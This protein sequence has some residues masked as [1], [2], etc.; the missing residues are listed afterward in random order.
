MI[1]IK[2]LHAYYGPVEVLKGIDV[3][4][5]DGE[6]TCLIGN[7]GAGKST[8]LKAISGMVN[9]TGS[10]VT[11]DN[12]NLI[13][14]KA[15]DIAKLGIIHVPE[16][17]H[18]FPGLTVEENLEAGAI[19]WHGFFGGKTYKNDLEEVYEL[20]PRLKERRN[21]LSWS[22]SGGEQQMLAIGRGLMARPKMLLLDEPSMGLAPVVV[23]ELFEKIVEINKVKGLPILLVEQNARLAMRICQNT[24]VMEQ[25]RIV[26]SGKSSDLLDDPKI[27]Q[28]YLGKFAMNKKSQK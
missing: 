26:T 11:G 5:P 14:K 24:Y 20:F 23:A 15:T 17:R 28:A 16:G 2:K 19:S 7:N 13:N 21:Q 6:I 9:R 22:L 25:G 27:I 1:S 4:V 12:I 18:V 3:E 8:L 10:I